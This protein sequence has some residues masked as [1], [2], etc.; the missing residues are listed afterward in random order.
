MAVKHATKLVE[1]GKSGIKINPLGLGCMGMSAFY[2]PFPPKEESIKVIHRALELGINFFDTALIYGWGA[3]EELLGEAIRTAPHTKRS[4]V[5]IATKFGFVKGAEGQY[6]VSSKPE[7][8]KQTCVNSLAS[9]KLDYIDLFYQHR[10]DPNTPI[11]ETVKAMAELVKEG[12]VKAL[13]LSECSAATL[14]RAH[15]VH[16]IAAVQVEYSLWSTDIENNDLLNTCRELG[17]TVVAYSP[18]ARGFLSGQI[19]KF[20][21]LEADDWRRHNPRFQPENFAKNIELVH[22]VES[23]AK[24]KKCTPSQLALAW[25]LNQ[26][27]VVA[28]PGTKKIQYLED[29]FGCLN[30][31]ITPEDEKK[32][33]DFL[34]VFVVAGTR[35]PEAQMKSVNI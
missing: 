35:Y 15:A 23:L 16:P 25:V 18:L 20:E 34:K 1:L 4:D 9:L 29:N 26:P 5:V 24:E 17:V 3:N 7:V 2:A 32:I 13:G 22:V 10:V 21:D 11:E 14:R 31:T 6:G 19:K 28:I 12:K 27:G 8:V 30:V 33:R